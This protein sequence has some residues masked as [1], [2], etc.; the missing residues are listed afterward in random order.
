MRSSYRPESKSLGTT[1]ETV[2]IDQG[3]KPPNHRQLGL[4]EDWQPEAHRSR[5]DDEGRSANFHKPQILG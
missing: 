2:E 4:V 3:R 5:R 1:R